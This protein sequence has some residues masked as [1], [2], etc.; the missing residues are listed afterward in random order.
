MALQDHLTNYHLFSPS[1]TFAKLS[2]NDTTLR[3]RQSPIFGQEEPDGCDVDNQAQHGDDDVGVPERGHAHSRDHK[4]C[5]KEKKRNKF[6]QFEHW[7]ILR[8]GSD[9]LILFHFLCIILPGSQKKKAGASKKG[10]ICLLPAN[11]LGLS[12]IQILFYLPANVHKIRGNERGGLI[13]LA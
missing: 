8:E 2:W 13:L 9:K 4:L 6:V 11:S 1:F 12:L 7:S 5:T 10:V 3:N